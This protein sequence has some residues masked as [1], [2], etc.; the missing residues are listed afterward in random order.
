MRKRGREERKTSLY[1]LE[2]STIYIRSDVVAIA[3]ALARTNKNFKCLLSRY[4]YIYILAAAPVQTSDAIYP[5]DAPQNWRSGGIGVGERELT[6][7]KQ[8]KTE[9]N[10]C[11]CVCVYTRKEVSWFNRKSCCTRSAALRPFLPFTISAV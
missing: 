3:R 11:V 6:I 9:M 2:L 4:I 7:A 5:R 1:N 10:V 8:R